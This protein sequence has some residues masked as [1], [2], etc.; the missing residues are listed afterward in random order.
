MRLRHFA[1]LGLAGV[2]LLAGCQPEQPTGGKQRPKYYRSSI[3]LSPSTTEIQQTYFYGAKLQGRTSSCNYPPQ[4]KT[5]GIVCDTKPN[6]ELITQLKPEVVFYDKTLYNESDIAKI[7]SSAPGALIIEEDVHTL[8]D[9]VEFLRVTAGHIGNEMAVNEYCDKVM[10]TRESV[11]DIKNRPTTMIITEA[12]NGQMMVAGT[13]TFI[14][15][16]VRGCGADVKGPDADKFV[17][18]NAEQ[19]IQTN[20]DVILVNEPGF[21]VLM[22]DGRFGSVKAVAATKPILGEVTAHP[23]DPAAKAKLRVLPVSEDLLLRAG[24]RVQNLMDAVIV[25]IRGAVKP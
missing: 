4:V 16:V 3:S 8:D 25:G 23:D 21:K 17:P 19:F 14:A 12:E 11:S 13:K 2:L 7:K 15:D 6:Y 20:P 18:L 24:S 1:A 9:Y 10:K 22:G 5:T